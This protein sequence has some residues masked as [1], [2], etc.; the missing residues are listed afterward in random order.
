[1]AVPFGFGP[2][3]KLHSLLIEI[4]NPTFLRFAQRL[5]RPTAAVDS[6]F[7][8]WDRVPTPRKR[9]TPHRDPAFERRWP[10]MGYGGSA[11]STNSNSESESI[12]MN[13]RS[14]DLHAARYA[15]GGS[16]SETFDFGDPLFPTDDELDMIGPVQGKRVLEIGSGACACGIAL[17]RKG[18]TVTCVDVSQEQ[19]RRG[20]QNA[21]TT[22]VEVRTVLGNAY[23]LG[24]LG[25]ERFDLAVAIASLQYVPDLA[26]ALTS[27]FQALLPN[28]RMVFSIPH[29][30]MDA[31]D[32]SVLSA[33]DGADP[34]YSYRG[35]V[36]WKW[37][38]GDEFEFVTY[39]RTVADII[40]HVIGAGFQ[41]K[42]IEELLPV[43][44]QPDWSEVEQE[45]RTRFPSFLV[46][47]AF[48]G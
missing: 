30:I 27:A 36:R 5:G 32:A 35:P 47:Q 38:P 22:G 13:A 2:A 42:R 11:V 4:V 3:S 15:G 48:K 9:R 17:A 18:A 39:R 34:R 44:P 45:V 6:L 10:S 28:G 29:P 12:A 31:F 1:M 16:S 26:R 14:W 43:Q 25:E 20:V 41:V 46:V 21:R 19:L 24:S 37:D 8:M 33:E 23:D 40:N 7:W